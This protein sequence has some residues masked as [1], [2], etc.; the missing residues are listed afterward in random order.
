MAQLHKELAAKK[1]V[2]IYKDRGKKSKIFKKL[3]SRFYDSL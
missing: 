3:S 2:V 1:P